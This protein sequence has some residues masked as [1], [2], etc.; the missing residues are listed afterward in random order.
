VTGI[1]QRESPRRRARALLA[2]LL[3]AVAALALAAPARAGGVK[4]IWGPT[5]LEAGN[6]ACPDPGRRCSAFPVYRRLG[7][8]VFQYQIHW[9]EVA[10]IRP[11]H[12]RDPD[13][14]AYDWGDVDLVAS[15]A[16]RYGIGLAILIQRAP[17][18]A[19]GG[20]SPIWAPRG[21]RGAREFANFA[22]AASKRLPS[23]HVWMIWGE[24]ARVENFRPLPV[25]KP[26]GPRIYAR[27]LDASY[28]SLKRAR[29]SNIVV[30]GMTLNGGTVM[31]TLFARYMKLPNGRPPRMDLWG[32]NPFDGRFPNLADPPIGRFRGFNDIDTFHREIRAVYRRGHRKVPRLWLSE[33]TVISGRPSSIF[34]GFHVSLRAQARWLRAAYRIARRTRYVAALGWF[35]LL[36]EPPGPGNANWGLMRVDGRPK[37][38]FNA[39]RHVP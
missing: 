2:A 28:A 10:P 36:D 12:P 25:N 33:W 35:T 24:A 23:V 5:E 3:C 1:V 7:V 26:R 15:E 34:L 30:G 29:R 14:P 22:Y 6:Q 13:D 18:W 4:A 16:K 38:S 9:D 39:Y 32:H 20:R 31:P 8:D 37:P 17:R 19:N 11:A 27:I 21:R